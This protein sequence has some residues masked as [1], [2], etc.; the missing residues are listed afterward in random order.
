ML[1]KNTA[2]GMKMEKKDA[3]IVKINNKNCFFSNP[4]E[5]LQW[6]KNKTLKA[7]LGNTYIDLMTRFIDISMSKVKMI[8][9]MRSHVKKMMENYEY[10]YINY[11]FS[12]S[13]SKFSF[14]ETKTFSTPLQ[15]YNYFFKIV[16]N[17]LSTEHKSWLHKQSIKSD[18]LLTD[19]IDIFTQANKAVK[20]KPNI[21][22]WVKEE[23]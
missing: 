17:T 4:E 10:E 6:L 7:E 1:V 8:S 22:K 23:F 15:K 11:I 19:N 14:A 20:S 5:H 21:N 3:Y 16:L 2:T 9:I 13:E 12:L 18:A